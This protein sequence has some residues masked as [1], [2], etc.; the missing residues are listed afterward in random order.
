MKACATNK[1]V[2]FILK[3]RTSYGDGYIQTFSSGL[4]N[5]AKMV[6]DMLNENW[7]ESKIVEVIDNNGIDKEVTEYR[8]DIVIIEALWVIPSKF[9]VLQKLHPNVKWIIRIHSEIPF[10]SNEGVAMEWISEYMKYRNVYVSFNSKR[11]NTE[12]MNVISDKF[13]FNFDHKIVYLPNFY[14]LPKD[15]SKRQDLCSCGHLTDAPCVCHKQKG[16]HIGCFGAIRPMKN[17]LLQAVAAIQFADLMNV[18]LFFHINS[19][20]IENRGDS[21]L[22]NLRNLFIGTKHELVEHDWM[23]RN[24]FL[25]VISKMDL[26]MQVSFS[27]TFNI[28][29]ADM[30]SQN[31]PI[32]VSNEIEWIFP[33]FYTSKTSSK[34][35]TFS[36]F[37]SWLTGKIKL[38]YLNRVGLWLSAQR[39]RIIWLDVLDRF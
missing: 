31:V 38:H 9:D 7:V 14:K 16:V 34:L 37:L 21:V 4:Y 32:V 20:R 8:P 39:A 22:K 18:K 30:V 10:L 23:D 13:T 1:K 3:K 15:Y 25:K 17:Q 5:S 29:S 11:T 28:V 36:L 6:S 26:G 27:E 33:L 12:M 2:L 19:K 35:M 24:D